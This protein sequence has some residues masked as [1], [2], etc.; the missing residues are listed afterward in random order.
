M[1]FHFLF[2][3]KFVIT[4]IYMDKRPFLLGKKDQ[5]STTTIPYDTVATTLNIRV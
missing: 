5:E 3:K 2:F 4:I 1:T